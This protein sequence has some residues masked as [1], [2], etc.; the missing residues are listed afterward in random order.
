[1]DCSRTL[2]CSLLITDSDTIQSM[3][4]GD[5]FDCG[6]FFLWE[7]EFTPRASHPNPA[8]RI[9]AM[10]LCQHGDER[11]SKVHRSCAISTIRRPN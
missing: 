8:R 1:M 7:F 6:A 2:Q 11:H 3:L 5:I 9:E 4:N 10:A